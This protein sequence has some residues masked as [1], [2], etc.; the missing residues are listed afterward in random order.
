MRSGK[1]LASGG[2]MYRKTANRRYERHEKDRDIAAVLAMARSRSARVDETV[3]QRL[4]FDWNHSQADYPRERCIQELFA[5]QAAWTP[6]ATALVCGDEQL[7]YGELDRR[8]NRL[9]H[10]LRRLGVGPE[11][12]VGLCL[13]RCP[14]MIVALLAILKAGGAYLPLDPSYPEERLAY[15]IRDSGAHLV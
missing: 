7:T 4:L 15:M 9:A 6:D 11:V 13:D 14:D 3:R 1:S 12:I 10:R 8:S 5:E 2:S